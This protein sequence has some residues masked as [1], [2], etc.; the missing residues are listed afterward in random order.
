[1]RL[2]L[3]THIAVWAVSERKRLSDEALDR[4]L[5]PDNDKYVSVVSLWEIAIKNS[6]RRATGRSGLLPVQEAL[7]AFQEAGLRLLPVLPAHAIAVER[8]ADHHRDPFDRLLVAQALVEPMY[9]VTHD[10][11]IGRYG[12]HIILV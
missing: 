1:M 6:A 5:D 3:D 12:E 10:E 2:L 11:T 7:E 4:L 9:L 8:L